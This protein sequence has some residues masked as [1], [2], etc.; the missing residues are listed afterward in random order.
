MNTTNGHQPSAVKQI[1][2]IYTHF[3]PEDF[4]FADTRTDDGGLF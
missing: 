3:L 4:S 2:L 1:N